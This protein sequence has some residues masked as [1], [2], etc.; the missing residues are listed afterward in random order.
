VAYVYKGQMSFQQHNNIAENKA[1][2]STRGLFC[3]KW[4]VKT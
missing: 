2:T 1:L 3:V 4:D